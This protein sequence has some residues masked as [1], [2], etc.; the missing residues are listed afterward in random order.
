VAVLH[1]TVTHLSHFCCTTTS[2]ISLPH[3]ISCKHQLTL[4]VSATAHHSTLFHTIATLILQQ[5]LRLHH[6]HI[7]SNATSLFPRVAQLIILS[8]LNMHIYIVVLKLFPSHITITSTAGTQPPPP[9]RLQYRATTTLFSRVAYARLCSRFPQSYHERLIS[10]TS[11]SL[12]ARK[13]MSTP[14]VP[15]VHRLGI[16]HELRPLARWQN[17][18]EA[19]CIH[20]CTKSPPLSTRNGSLQLFDRVST[21]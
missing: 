4:S 10:L 9:V 21:L 2:R 11:A 1:E 16:P 18:L 17:P 5:E 19:H 12:N 6:S 3:R 14:Q 20:V 15:P 13:R 8:H 7:K